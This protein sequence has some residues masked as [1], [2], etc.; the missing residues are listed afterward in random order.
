MP[1]LITLLIATLLAFS[2]TAVAQ[3][4]P[5]AEER[6]VIEKKIQTMRVY[7]LTD[8]L[9]LDEETA[10]R[11]F[12]Y[13]KE[14]DG[15]IRK[16]HRTQKKNRRAL[17]KA[18]QDGGLDDAA[19][20]AL[21]TAIS[22]TEQALIRARVEQMDGLRDILSPE[23]RAKFFVAQEKFD[24]ELRRKLREARRDRKMERRRGERE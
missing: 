18:V 17:K 16:L 23:Q 2:T 3:E 24:R 21:L 22:D 13:L 10:I 6:E 15:P 4:G 12:P 5:S 8:A 19:V 11:L 20:D 1:R 14:T 7:A 9:D